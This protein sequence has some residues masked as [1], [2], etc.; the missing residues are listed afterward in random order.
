M[1]G[2]NA[3]VAV[4]EELRNN[5]PPLL[6][7]AYSYLYGIPIVMTAGKTAYFADISGAI[8]TSTQNITL[9]EVSPRNNYHLVTTRIKG[10]AADTNPDY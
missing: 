4:L 8:A 2:C 10:I 7:R 1:C 3:V 6:I 5:V 9:F